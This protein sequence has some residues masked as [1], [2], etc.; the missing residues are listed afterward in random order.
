MQLVGLAV[1]LLKTSLLHGSNCTGF[2]PVLKDPWKVDL[3]VMERI[4]E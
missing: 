4:T 3:H 2:G 1:E